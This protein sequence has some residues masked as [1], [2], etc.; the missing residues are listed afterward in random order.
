[1][2]YKTLFTLAVLLYIVNVCMG[3]D[4]QYF[5][6]GNQYGLRNS[7]TNKVVLEATYDGR[8][9]GIGYNNGRYYYMLR[10]G[11]TVYIISSE[12]Y[13]VP[14]G[15]MTGFNKERKDTYDMSKGAKYYYVRRDNMTEVWTVDGSFLLSSRDALSVTL[16]NT[17]ATIKF[18]DAI[19]KADLA[20]LERRDRVLRNDIAQ[21]KKWGLWDNKTHSWVNN[22]R[23]KKRFSGKDNYNEPNT[24]DGKEYYV[25]TDDDDWK[26]TVSA[27]DFSIIGRLTNRKL[28]VE[29]YVFSK[30]GAIVVER[31]Y[32]TNKNVKN[33][34]VDVYGNALEG[35]TWWLNIK[36]PANRD[37]V[38][39]IGQ[40]QR[41]E[42]TFAEV[43]KLTRRSM[44]E[45][46]EK[47]NKQ[48]QLASFTK[49]ATSYVQPR[50]T[51]WQKKGE[52]EKVDDYQRRVGGN[53]RQRK[54]DELSLEAE[55]L[56]LQEN[57]EKYKLTDNLKLSD[58]DSENEVFAILSPKYGRL[59]IPVPMS[60]APAF[61]EGFASA[62]IK[63]ERFFVENDRIAVAQFDIKVGRNTYHYTNNNSLNYVQYK[64][65]PN[66]F[67]LQDINIVSNNKTTSS[68]QP[69]VKI[70]SPQSGSQYD[71]G[72][73]SFCIEVVPGE[74]QT[75]NLYVSIN[76]AEYQLIQPSK[77]QSKGARMAKGKMY[78]LNLPTEPG[79]AVNL[80][81]KAKDQYNNESNEKRLKL[82]Y[83]GLKNKP[84]LFIFAVGISDY[85]DDGPQKLEFATKDAID[86]TN[87]VKKAY[88]PE[89]YAELKLQ[90]F[91]DKKA[92]TKN[93]TAE[94]SKLNKEVL[95]NDIV[96]F[97][98][99][100]HGIQEYSNTYFM[101]YDTPEE[102]PSQGLNFAT[103]EGNIK[104]L[105]ERKA[106]VLVFM[107]A[108]HSGALMGTKGAA[109]KITEM[110]LD[111]A[112][113]FYSST[114]S[115]KSAEDPN[116][117]NGVFTAALIKGIQGEAA[118]KEGE[119]TYLTLSQY[120][121][122]FVAEHNKGQSPVV[123]GP[124]DKDILLF[125]TK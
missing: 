60:N 73:V 118:N 31:L 72:A 69:Q 111:D 124:E 5:K 40:G 75:V 44:K 98:F 109:Q 106:K 17:T 71:N 92:T 6:S 12:N 22:R 16:N 55:K 125:H 79:K 29:N 25:V 102:T 15:E 84:R 45:T 117:K 30:T 64:L 89:D 56:F 78:D 91:T 100:G 57:S 21:D 23:Y 63:N 115:Q 37:V 18:S 46:E 121:R 9:D 80:V 113:Q 107:D 53:N 94:L 43:A 39:L 122:N 110:D 33:S 52:F 112:V 85:P 58:Y 116:L 95:Q 65:D 19:N 1:M 38:E 41:E 47:Q 61:K 20:A 7:K 10:K 42:K 51:L 70:I 66:S 120:I 4:V 28:F 90:M 24:F 114:S 101:T 13:E 26:L 82:T 34:L 87:A 99:S 2:K 77:Q 105:T 97:Y 36:F 54:I 74:G 83:V 48:Q 88:S 50:I 103:L 49:Y 35:C 59:L 108:C 67:D 86:F 3:Q 76:G 27:T 8:A 11:E 93:I 104:D 81:F 32:G 62:K 14:V 96:M 123:R 68:K 119:I